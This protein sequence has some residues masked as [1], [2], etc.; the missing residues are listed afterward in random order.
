[1]VFGAE[2]NWQVKKIF[3]FKLWQ[4]GCWKLVR[5]S[6]VLSRWKTLVWKASEE[7]NPRQQ[8]CLIYSLILDVK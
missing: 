6:S 8:F 4:E 1:V 7:G 5:I 2:C 3:G